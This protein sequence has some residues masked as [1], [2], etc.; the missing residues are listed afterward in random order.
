MIFNSFSNDWDEHRP[1]PGS[2][3]SRASVGRRLG[4]E[5][6]G[7]SLYH[8]PPGQWSWPYHAHYGNEELLVVLDGRPTLRTPHGERERELRAGDT[9]GDPRARP[10]RAT[11]AAARA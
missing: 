10:R 11:G 6:L 7:A 1:H 9:S 8:L 5:M 2:A 4:G 3:W